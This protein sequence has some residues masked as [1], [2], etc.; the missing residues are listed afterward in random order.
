LLALQ[1]AAAKVHANAQDHEEMVRLQAEYSG[2]I[3]EANARAAIWARRENVTH[4]AD[5]WR[6]EERR[7]LF[8]E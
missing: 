2:N 5:Y 4:G 3:S 7:H 1:D 6:E 8:R